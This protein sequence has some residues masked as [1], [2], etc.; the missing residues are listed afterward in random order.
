MMMLLLGCRADVLALIAAVCVVAGGTACVASPVRDNPPFPSVPT[1]F[2]GNI[3]EDIESDGSKFQL[4]GTVYVDWDRNLTRLDYTSEDTLATQFQDYSAGSAFV[5]TFDEEFAPQCTTLPITWPIGNPAALGNATFF[6]LEEFA[7]RICNTWYFVTPAKDLL[8]FFF[9]VTSSSLAGM[10][11]KSPALNYTLA[12][13]TLDATAPKQSAF[14][15]PS[16]CQG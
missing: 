8:Y 3:V 10:Q 5:V 13:T 9:D 14:H 16:V 2:S 4:V 12:Y 6:G 11:F 1:K 7:N 15:V